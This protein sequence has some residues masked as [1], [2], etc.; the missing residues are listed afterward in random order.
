MEPKISRCPSS[1][2]HVTIYIHS[3]HSDHN[4]RFNVDLF[5]LPVHP[6]VIARVM[7]NLKYMHSPQI[8]EA[9]SERAQDLFSKIVTDLEHAIYK[10]FILKKKVHI[11]AYYLGIIGMLIFHI[12][13]FFPYD[14][15]HHF[16]YK[17]HKSI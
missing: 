11:P 12:T 1:S 16:K 9:I 10:F 15:N 14:C 8:V 6:H 5:F 13:L 2:V 4:S 17:F 7:E 3:K